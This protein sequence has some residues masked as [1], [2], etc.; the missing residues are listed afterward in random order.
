MKRTKIN[1][2]SK[3]RAKDMRLYK[4]IRLDFLEDHPLCEIKSKVCTYVATEI[5]HMKGRGMYYLVVSTWEAACH[6]CGQFVTNNPTWA[7][8]NGHALD[9]IGI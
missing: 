8:E 9:R 4:K 3:R 2:V 7:F 5:S 6:P 1:S